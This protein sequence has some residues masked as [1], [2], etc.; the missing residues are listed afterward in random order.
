MKFN[1]PL[2]QPLPKECQKAAQIFKSFVDSANNGLDGVIP[3]TVLE[4]AKGFAIFTIFKAGFLFSARAGSGVVIAKLD[5]GTWSAPSAIGTA[6]LGVGGQA[7]AEMT[8]FLVVLNSRSAVKSFMSAGSL[9]LGGN[10][11]VAIGPLGRNGEASGS[12]NTSGKVAAMYS[13]SKTRGLFGGVS[14]E[15]SVIVERQDANAQAYHADVSAKQLLSGAIPPPE[16][17]SPLIKTL[18]ACTGLPGGRRWVEELHSNRPRDPY[19]FGSMESPGNEGSPSGSRYFPESPSTSNSKLSK[20]NKSK[21]S[22]IS[23]PPVNWGRRKSSGSYFSEFH[24]PERAP[25]P[26]DAEVSTPSPNLSPEDRPSPRL[27]RALNPATGFF[28]TKFQSDYVSEDQLRQHPPLGRR[29]TPPVAKPPISQEERWEPGSPF[30]DLPPFNQ[31]RSNM[32]DAT[33]HRRAFSAYA[34]SSSSGSRNPFD[35]QTRGAN[36]FGE[37]EDLLGLGDAAGG[38]GAGSSTL[39]RNSS[40][41]S[42][43]PKLAPKAELT[44]P[45]LPHEGVARAIALFDFKAVQPGDLSF[46]KGQVI[47][48][49]EKSEDTNTWWRGRV[50]GAEGIF[51]A[52]FVEVV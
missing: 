6:G 39:G 45:L 52:N 14:I 51:P 44:R 40:L 10:L 27:G 12:L 47:T 35:A 37:D 49:T 7:G 24:E 4:N 32:S 21:A 26:A 31:A 42:G 8:D 20:K 48:V 22:S 30:N 38:R 29:D 23:F 16:W 1:T 19:M 9:T 11:S 34:P 43:K 2:P 36:G 46:Q 28:E 13:Y 33:S 50:D 18:E 15:G 17:A 5:D 41:S 3:R 25:R